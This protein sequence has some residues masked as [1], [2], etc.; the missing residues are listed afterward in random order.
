MI[1]HL[2]PPC[3]SGTKK[4]PEGRRGVKKMAKVTKATLKSFVKKNRNQ[5]YINVK[6]VF[7]GYTDGLESQNAGFKKIEFEGFEATA[8][9]T[10]RIKGLW[11][12]N[13]GGDRFHEFDDGEYTGIEYHNAC[14]HGILAIKKSA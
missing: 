3:K 1:K 4:P 7:S 13:G 2:V 6:S 12:V 10:L 5:L 8:E 11:L 9:H 14:G